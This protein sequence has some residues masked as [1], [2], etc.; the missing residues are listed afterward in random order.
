MIAVLKIKPLFP[1]IFYREAEEAEEQRLLEEELAKEKEA[2]KE[3]MRKRKPIFK[4]QEK[5][6]EELKGYSKLNMELTKGTG[7][8]AV[9]SKVRQINTHF[10]DMIILNID[11]LLST[12]T[13]FKRWLLD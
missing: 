1:C 4:A 9:Q 3:G 13:R 10:L 7:V 5:S 8:K 2:K 11:F 12:D 6:E